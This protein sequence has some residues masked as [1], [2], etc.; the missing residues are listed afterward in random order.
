MNLLAWPPWRASTGTT[1]R[2]TSLRRATTSRGAGALGERGEVADVE[3]EDGDLDLLALEHRAL[4]QHAVGHAA[5]RRSAERLVQLL[6]LLQAGDHLVERAR[7]PAGLVGRRS[8][9]RA[10]RGRRRRR[11]RSRGAGRRS[12]CEDRARQQHARARARS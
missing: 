9:A 2:R 10:P 5:G 12:G 7:Q 3:E 1:A 4:G 6:A 11:A 8:P